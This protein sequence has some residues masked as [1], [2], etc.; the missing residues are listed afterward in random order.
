MFCVDFNIIFIWLKIKLYTK[1]DILK[2]IDDHLYTLVSVE[3][4]LLL[5]ILLD[6][7]EC[8]HRQMP[9]HVSWRLTPAWRLPPPYLTPA[10]GVSH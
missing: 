1:H 7:V 8:V 10:L 5:F 4:F 3:M 2:K 9:G 6:K